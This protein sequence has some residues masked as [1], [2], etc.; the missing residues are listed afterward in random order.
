M[1]SLASHFFQNEG[2]MVWAIVLTWTEDG[3]LYMAQVSISP[4]SSLVKIS[5]YYTLKSRERHIDLIGP[6]GWK[7]MCL[8]AWGKHDNLIDSTSKTQK[9]KTNQT[10][11]N[12]NETKKPT[13]FCYCATVQDEAVELVK[14]SLTINDRFYPTCL[15]MP[16]HPGRM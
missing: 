12:K 11:P 15:G 7:N 1:N 3:L 4:S 2:N 13:N 8:W 6:Q 5:G 16:W 9:K 14:S 10:K